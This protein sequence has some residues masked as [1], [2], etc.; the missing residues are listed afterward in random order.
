MEVSPPFLVE[1]YN[2]SEVVINDEIDNELGFVTLDHFHNSVG[3]LELMREVLVIL[4]P[5]VA[6]MDFGSTNRRRMSGL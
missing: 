2:N 5:E 4:V 6:G 1:I 3:F